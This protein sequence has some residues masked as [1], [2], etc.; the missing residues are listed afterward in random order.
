MRFNN[1]AASRDW[2]EAERV[3]SENLSGEFPFD[4]FVRPPAMVPLAC[5]CELGWHGCKEVTRLQKRET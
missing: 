3:L 5:K 1:A 2:T 4:H